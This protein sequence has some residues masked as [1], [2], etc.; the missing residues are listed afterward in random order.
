MQ[1]GRRAVVFWGIST[2][3][4]STARVI[5]RNQSKGAGE[6]GLVAGSRRDDMGMGTRQGT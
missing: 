6:E 5:S 1:K 3:R 4:P 2:L